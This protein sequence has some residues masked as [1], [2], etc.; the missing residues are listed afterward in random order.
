[1]PIRTTSKTTLANDINK[2]YFIDRTYDQVSVLNSLSYEL[3]NRKR[4][5]NWFIC[6]AGVSIWI[7]HAA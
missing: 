6:L 3:K 2:A 4:H 1:M 7:L 5:V